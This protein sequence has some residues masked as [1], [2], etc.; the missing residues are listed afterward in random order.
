MIFIAGQRRETGL[1][2]F[3]SLGS[4]LGFSSGIILEVFQISGIEH[5]WRDELKSLDRYFSPFSPKCLRCKV[6]ILSG[7]RALDA[8]LF[9]IASF[10]HLSST[11]SNL[12]QAEHLR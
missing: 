6:E 7:P 11:T 10:P 8:L 1:Y 9:L 5:C 4:F 2:D 3:A 12:P